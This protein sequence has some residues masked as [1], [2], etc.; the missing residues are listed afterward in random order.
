MVVAY[1]SV[2]F[3]CYTMGTDSG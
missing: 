1:V 3:F 2:S